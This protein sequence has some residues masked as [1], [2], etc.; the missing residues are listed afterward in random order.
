MRRRPRLAAILVALV[1]GSALFGSSPTDQ[2]RGADPLAEAQARQRELQETL[3]AQRRELKDLQALA[4]TLD[5]RLGAAIAELAAV[6]T[7]YERVAGLLVQVEAQIVEVTGRLEALR[8]RIATLDEMLVTLA[9]EVERQN[10]DLEARETLLQEH[11]RDAYERSRTSLL[12]V[13]LAA[14]SF[15]VIATQ[16]G[17]LLTVSEQDAALADEIR[18]IR[19]ALE[20]NRAVLRRGRAELAAS[21]DV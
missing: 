5:Q 8:A 7:E 1:V 10:R 2:A 4:A 11:Y 17:Y 16:V 21:R 13:L 9:I 19:S 12:E 18:E 14:D 3:A 6:S 20:S 15:E